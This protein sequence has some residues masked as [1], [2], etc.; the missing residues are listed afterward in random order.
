MTD[1]KILTGKIMVLPINHK[2]KVLDFAEFPEQKEAAPQS[3]RHP[4]R[5]YHNRVSRL[6]ESA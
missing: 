3:G 4:G 6:F 1:E 5:K 2:Q